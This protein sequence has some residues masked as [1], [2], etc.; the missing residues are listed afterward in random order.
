MNF[1]SELEFVVN[2]NNVDSIT[3]VQTSGFASVDSVM[4]K[5]LRATSGKW[6]PGR[7]DGNIVKEKLK[8]WIHIFSG[9]IMD[10]R[11][12]EFM[13]QGNKHFANEA[14][15]EAIKAYD[16]VLYYD[17]LDPQAV[18]QKGLALV[19]IGKVSDACILWRSFTKYNVPEVSGLIKEYCK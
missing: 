7:I 8:I 19:K 11:S 5:M 6:M 12:G 10:K 2:K 17:E 18:T 15:E 1:T 13:Q 14:Y 9:R 3:F 4:I 16:K